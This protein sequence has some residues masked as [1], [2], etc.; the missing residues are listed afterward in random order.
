MRVQMI[1]E[2][3]DRASRPIQAVTKAL[4]GTERAAKAANALGKIGQGLKGIGTTAALAGGALAGTATTV[5]VGMLDTARAFERYEVQMASLEG[6]Q[7]KGRAAMA[8]VSD[9]AAKTPLELDQV[10]NAYAQMKAFGLDPTNGSL[11]ALVDTMAK[12]GQ[13][14]EQLSGLTMAIGQAWTKGKLQGEEIMQLMERQVPVLDILGA[15]YGKTAAEISEMASKGKL[16][17]DAI[18]V[19]V[20]AMGERAA[21]ASAAFSQTFDGITSNLLDA[22]KRFQLAVMQGGLFDWMKGRAGDLLNTVNR[23]AADGSLQRLA[24]EIG[25]N[26]QSVL[27]VMWSIMVA[28][29]QAFQ[30]AAPYVTAFVDMVGGARNAMLL[31]A[32]LAILKPLLLIGQGI[33]MLIGALTPLGPLLLALAP[34]LTIAAG[35]LKAFGLALLTTPVGWFMLAVVAIA[36]AAYLIYRNWA[37]IGPWLASVWQGVMAT[38]TGAWNAVVRWAAGAWGA[39]IRPFVAGW[40]AVEAW[41]SGLTWPTLPQLALF[42]VSPLAGLTAMLD[43]DWQ[44]VAAWFEGFSWPALPAIDVAAWLA[45]L[46]GL[47]GKL[48]DW[49]GRAASAASA[50]VGLVTDAIGSAFSAVGNGMSRVS[51][52]VFGPSAASVSASAAD[53]ANVSAAA[54]NARAMINA[55]P[56]AASA[57]VAAARGVLAAANFHSHGVAMMTTLASGIRAGAGAAV[58]AARSTVQQIRDHLPHSPAKTGPLSDLDRVQF[59]QTLAGAMRAGAP[60]AIAAAAAIAGGIS[61]QLPA[62]ASFALAGSRGPARPDMPGITSAL[63]TGGRAPSSGSDRGVSG[64]GPLTLNLTFSPALNGAGGGDLLAQL[65][66]VLPQL[67]HEIGEIVSREMA[68]RERVKH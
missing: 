58:A 4:L 14:A 10:M 15:H 22:W 8:W 54:E 41:F 51:E 23:M 42:A 27:M 9:F 44:G 12:S 43:L 26:V 17:R 7:E 62:G 57:A 33:A 32:G 36:G 28:V 35:A 56:P 50:A 16:G 40:R 6:S 49:G 39:F 52:M 31:L 13:G 63:P 66:S 68:R 3:I 60:A 24:E 19:L 53:V 30:T 67:G 29:T 34:A 65:K 38:L 37:S 11:L 45:P 20:K 25:S 55:I 64:S 5:A 47:I 1:L 46:E 2:A 21:G 48:D 61:A 18:D 59:G